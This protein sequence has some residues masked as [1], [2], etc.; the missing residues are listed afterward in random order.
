M[1]QVKILFCF[2]TG[3]MG[4]LKKIWDINFTKT[5]CLSKLSKIQNQS[6]LEVAKRPTAILKTFLDKTDRSSA[7]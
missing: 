7:K 1:C 5:G 3:K 4:Y 6:Q 2:S